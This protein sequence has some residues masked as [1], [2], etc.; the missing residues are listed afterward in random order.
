[1]S[2][3]KV[4]TA[5]TK[6]QGPFDLWLLGAALLLAGLGL[7]MVFS[8]SGVMAE[9]LN[10]NRYYFFQRQA[11]F[12]LVSLTLM[13]LCAW[14]PRKVLHGPVYLWLFAIVGL[15]VLTLVP[16]FSVKA[17]GARRWMHFGP[18][19]LQPM[20]LAKVVLVMYLAY[21]FSQKQKLVRSFSVGFI[22]PVVV[23]GFL[24]LIL[25]LQ[26]DFGGA[27][28]LGMLFFLMSLVGGTRMTYLAVSMMFGVGA[29][30]LLI[31]SS[32]YRFKRWFAF[33]D[34]FKDPQNVGYQLVQSFYAFGSGGITGAGFGA[35]KQ[36]LFYLPEAHNDFIM[37]VLGEELGFIGISIV[38]ICIGILLWRAFRVA[39][40]Q[41]D[42]RDRFTAYGMALVLGLGFLLNLAVVLGC[43]PPKGVAMPFLSYGGSNLLSCFLCV[44]ILLN[45]SRSART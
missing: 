42:L 31:A 33:L 9:R 28:F 27:V 22:P 37:A 21:F 41:D 34:P 30:G 8:S 13:A 14:M 35:G 26:P 3:V 7:V 5:E 43:V 6:K 17:G 12:A 36:K 45:L 25:L 1:M 16:P 23:T 20:E 32:P 24:G 11:L 10:G 19:T 38:F 44:G 39:L 18:A 40:A 2:R 15:L 29:M 4:A